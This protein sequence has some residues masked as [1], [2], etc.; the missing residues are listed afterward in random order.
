MGYRVLDC[1]TQDKEESITAGWLKAYE[2]R[3]QIIALSTG[4]G[5]V[6]RAHSP[7]PLINSRIAAR[8]RALSCCRGQ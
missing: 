8:K 2:D 7:L 4:F 5:E 6:N 3:G 1:S